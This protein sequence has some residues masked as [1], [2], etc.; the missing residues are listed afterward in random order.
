MVFAPAP[1]LTVTVEQGPDGPDIHL[2]AGG[3]GIWQARMIV[4]LG[5]RVVLCAVLGGEVGR[6][7]GPLI[8]AEGIEVRAVDGEATNGAY[9]HDRRAGKRLEIAESTGRPLSRHDLDELYSLALAE[10]M[11]SS[12]S[13]LS[14]VADPR[15]VPADVYRRLAGDL[16]RNGTR[17]AADLSGDYLSAVLDG[18]VSFLKVA[19]D[20][21]VDAG[22]ASGDDVEE[23]VPAMRRLRADGAEAVVVSR[24]DRSALALLDGDEPLEVLMPR[25]EAADSRGAGDSMTAGVAAVLAEGGDLRRAVRTGAAAGALNVTRHGLGTGRSD[26]VRQMVEHVELRPL[27]MEAPA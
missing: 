5:A 24:A 8:S 26:S 11:H 1:Q 16:H 27:A 10:G 15:V 23:L 17:V 2:H 20:E 18:G 22:R 7:L 14:G 19:H 6:V 12:L 21:L 13:L 25:L 4:A 9:V 3:Q